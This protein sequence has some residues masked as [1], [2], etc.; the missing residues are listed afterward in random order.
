MDE[1]TAKT[2][3]CPFS[4]VRDA[5]GGGPVNRMSSRDE[6]TR[7]LGTGC[8]AWRGTAQS[9]YCGLAGRDPPA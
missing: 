4:V 5:G 2:K 8:M 9:G 1:T 7:C 6:Q 3:W